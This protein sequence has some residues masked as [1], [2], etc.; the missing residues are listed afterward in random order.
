MN[1]CIH[2][3]GY[4]RLGWAEFN[5]MEFDIWMDGWRDVMIALGKPFR[6]IDVLLHNILF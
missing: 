6:L 5:D 4:Y 2:W 3:R 1:I